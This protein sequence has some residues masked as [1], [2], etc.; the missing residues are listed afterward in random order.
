VKVDAGHACCTLQYEK[1]V[2]A[3]REAV[4][5]VRRRIDPKPDSLATGQLTA[6]H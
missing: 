2:A 4:D 1:F 3:L 5:S 6:S